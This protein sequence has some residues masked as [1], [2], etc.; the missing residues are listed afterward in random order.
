MALFVLVRHDLNRSFVHR[1]TFVSVQEQSKGNSEQVDANTEVVLL[2]QARR[3]LISG[4][5]MSVGFLLVGTFR[6]NETELVQLL[7]NVFAAFAFSC[8]LADIY[9]EHRIASE[10]AQRH[11]ARYRCVILGLCLVFLVVYSSSA[12]ASLV[13]NPTAFLQKQARLR[14]SSREPGYSLH[15]LSTSVEWMLIYMLSPY[16]YTFHSNFAR[17]TYLG[18]N[19]GQAIP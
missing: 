14:W 4:L 18:N 9:Y 2:K 16:F 10:M 7:H 8:A 12:V 11:T 13:A 3:S 1:S 15:V 19:N 17:A 6:N 5:C